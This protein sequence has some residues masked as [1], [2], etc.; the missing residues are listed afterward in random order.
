MEKIGSVSRNEYGSG[1]IKFSVVARLFRA[2]KG[3]FNLVVRDKALA[4]VVRSLPKNDRR[5]LIEINTD[6]ASFKF[7]TTAYAMGGRCSRYVYFRAIKALNETWKDLYSL[8]DFTVIVY[9]PYVNHSAKN[10]RGGS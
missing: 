9:I 5:V 2:S 10:T 4:D 7:S 8:G 3:G 1:I 6:V